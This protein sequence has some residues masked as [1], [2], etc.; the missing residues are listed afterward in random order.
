MRCYIRGISLTALALAAATGCMQAPRHTNTLMFATNTKAGLHV[1]VDEKQI[2]QILIGYDRQEGVFMPLVANTTG[3]ADELKP[4][5]LQDSDANG[6]VQLPASCL[7]TGKHGTGI[8]DSYSVLATFA[9]SAAA[10]SS[11]TA[12]KAGGSVAQYFATGLAARALAET[13]GAAAI[14]TGDAALKSSEVAAAQQNLAAARNAALPTVAAFVNDG[15]GR[16]DTD[17]LKK[18]AEV[19]GVSVGLLTPAGDDQSI[20]AFKATLVER[21]PFSIDDFARKIEQADSD[22]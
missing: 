4:C 5:P 9:G 2:P 20:A 11:G 1:G 7:L 6:I 22:D 17:R 21:F 12:A 18:L 14:S 10:E 19:T 15:T 3:D 13:S 8:F 16:I